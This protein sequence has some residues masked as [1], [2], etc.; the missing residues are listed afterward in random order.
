MSGVLRLIGVN[1]RLHFRSPMALLY[2]YLFPTIFFVSF[3]VLYRH[4]DVPMA[5]H[6][7]ELLTV[8]VLGGACFGLPTTFVGERERGIWRRYKLVPLAAGAL[9]AALVI[10]R[11]FL[12]IPAALLQ[13]ALALAIGMP[14]P[15]HPFQ[16]PIAF[17]CVALAFLGLGL[18]IAM[19]ADSVPAVQALGQCIFLPMLILGGV[20]VPLAALPEW[21]QR[22]S[23]FL[24]GRYAVEAIHS[25]VAGDGLS[26]AR[27]S[28][29]ALLM[30]GLAAGVAG[31]A[32]FRW[33]SH[34]RFMANPRK[35]WVAVALSAW[36]I[37]GLVADPAPVARAPVAPAPVAPAAPVAP[38]LWRN[39]TPEEIAAIDFATLPP[40]AGVVAPIAGDGEPP[41]E[42]VIKQL[43]QMQ[44]GLDDWPPAHV[45]DPV[46]RVRNYLYVLAV[47]DI[48]Q[49]PLERHAPALIFDRLEKE[50]PR[51]DLVRLLY[52]VAEHPAEGDDRAVGQMHALGLGSGPSDPREIRDRVALYALKLLGRLTGALP[53]LSP[54]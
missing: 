42:A 35:G 19:M 12:L 48:F 30:I 16:L 31:A 21:A 10:A 52:W 25:T 4:E 8:T 34:E 20:A 32:M 9:T 29:V 17:T 40:D 44:R 45:A 13:I 46:Q 24:P 14:A 50:F 2:A 49:I 7:G 5:R 36:V 18:M 26:D 15:N 37:T 6:M 28:V 43:V 54:P 11:F 3:A 39:V 51:D 23:L 22:L 41:D 53:T 47:P 33:D 38:D 1:L 27:F